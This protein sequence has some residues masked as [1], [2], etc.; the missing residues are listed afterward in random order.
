MKPIKVFISSRIKELEEE[1][2]AI[3]EDTDFRK[4]FMYYNY[5]L[6]IWLRST[7]DTVGSNINP[8]F[9]TDHLHLIGFWT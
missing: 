2:N 4:V 7:P 9:P 3:E 6:I 8:I 1:R 5:T